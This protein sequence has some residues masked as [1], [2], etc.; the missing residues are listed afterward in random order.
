M[1]HKYIVYPVYGKG[2]TSG[3]FRQQTIIGTGKEYN[4]A[5]SFWQAIA[6]NEL[7]FKSDNL[8]IVDW[9]HYRF[10]TIYNGFESTWHKF[11]VDEFTQNYRWITPCEEW[12]VDSK[13]YIVGAIAV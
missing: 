9:A 4:D 11:K 13:G 5:K 7:K 3:C 2:K 1:N 6:N 12:E 10:K 8:I